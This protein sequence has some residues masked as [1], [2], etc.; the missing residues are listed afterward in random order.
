MFVGSGKTACVPTTG[1][2]LHHS[3]NGGKQK[4]DRKSEYVHRSITCV[5]KQNGRDV[6]RFSLRTQLN[7]CVCV[8]LYN[9]KCETAVENGALAGN[10]SA[11]EEFGGFIWT[12]SIQSCSQSACNSAAGGL[13]ARTLTAQCLCT[14]GRCSILSWS[15]QPAGGGSRPRCPRVLS[16]PSTSAWTWSAARRWSW[17]RLAEGG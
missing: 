8:C 1:W 13:P 9:I 17:S 14:S 15:A 16:S 12:Q 4:P 5:G 3:G 10:V 6:R 2:T 11:D 7:V